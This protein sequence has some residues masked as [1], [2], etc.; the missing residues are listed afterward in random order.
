MRLVGSLL[1]IFILESFAGKF[2]TSNERAESI[3][4]FY[5]EDQYIEMVY[6][7]VSEDHS[8]L[9]YDLFSKGMK[10]YNILRKK[11]VL[12]N[13]R[14]LTLIDYSLES[15]AKRLWL[16]DLEN[17]TVVY[18]IR[19]AHGKNTGQNRALHFSN[20]P[21]SRKS[22]LGFYLTGKTYFGK[23]GLSLYLDGLE[24]GINDNARKRYIVIHAANYVTPE[25]INKVG[26]LG[27]SFG[28]P[29]VNPSYAKDL[30]QR[31]KDKS[32][33][34]IYHPTEHY[35]EKSNLVYNWE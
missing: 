32:L 18:H 11:G 5:T 19:V 9:P 23:H 25:F 13:D 12:K 2:T 24:E 10:G 28:C 14:Y 27:R 30:I 16:I 6:H 4:N 33:L 29:A 21:T 31:I 22:S 34:F 7:L 15:T 20:R 1:F 35:T 26:R 8:S 17:D 3:T